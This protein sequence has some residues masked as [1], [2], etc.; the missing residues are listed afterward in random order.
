[1]VGLLALCGAASLAQSHELVIG[2]TGAALGALQRLADAY[3]RTQPAVRATVLPSLGSGGGLKALRAGAIQVAVSARPPD[4]AELAAGSSTVELGRT[5]FVV[6]VSR[7]NPTTSISRDQ[8]AALLAGHTVAWADGSA[9]RP[10]LRPPEDADS[11]SL[12]ALGPAVAS[13]LDLAQ[14]RPGVPVVLTDQDC[15]DRIAFTPGAFGP[16][17]LSLLLGEGRPLKALAIDGQAPGVRA[18]A[19]KRYPHVRTLW[20][21]IGPRPDP[22]TAGF[23]AFVRAPTGRALLADLGIWAP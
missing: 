18:L 9:A 5:A 12:R 22:R 3:V 16:S 6:A 13:A 2:G 11:V 7:D 15:A 1:M 21:V 10:V 23:V 19:E 8:L 17:T 20:L 14:Q 4:P